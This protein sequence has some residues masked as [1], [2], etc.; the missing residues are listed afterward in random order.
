MHLMRMTSS[1]ATM[2]SRVAAKKCV[3]WVKLGEATG[4]PTANFT[5]ILIARNAT[6]NWRNRE[7]GMQMS[8]NCRAGIKLL[9]PPR[10]EL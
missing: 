10:P 3:L 9:S 2:N 5:N 4:W 6:L 1:V 7:T 8:L